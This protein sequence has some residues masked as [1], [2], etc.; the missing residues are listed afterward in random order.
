MV[1]SERLPPNFA[2]CVCNAGVTSPDIPQ[3]PDHNIVNAC[4][5]ISYSPQ[6]RFSAMALRPQLA[7]L[8][9]AEQGDEGRGFVS[10]RVEA[11]KV[12]EVFT[13]TVTPRSLE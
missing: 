9:V 12:V 8:P 13:P 2:G 4:L 1:H 6:L 11:A 3:H 5:S 7:V 10:Y